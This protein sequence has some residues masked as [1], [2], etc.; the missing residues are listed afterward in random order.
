MKEHFKN[1]LLWLDV[2]ILNRFQ[3]ISNFIE[4]WFGLPV[5]YVAQFFFVIFTISECGYIVIHCYMGNWIMLT[6]LPIAL[7]FVWFNFFILHQKEKVGEGAINLI[8]M[9]LLPLRL[10][11]IIYLLFNVLFFC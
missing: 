11:T 1:N 7:I 9:F 3:K 4:N 2:R 8:D 5:F 6:L 10:V